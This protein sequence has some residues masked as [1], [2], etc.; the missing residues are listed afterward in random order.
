MTNEDLQIIAASVASEHANE[1]TDALNGLTSSDE[2]VALFMVTYLSGM[3]KHEGLQEYTAKIM[4]PP[5]GMRRAQEPDQK[6]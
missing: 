5:P 2:E 1:L 3:G 6:A 4:P